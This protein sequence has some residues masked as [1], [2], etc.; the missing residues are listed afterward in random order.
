MS[1]ASLENVLK[2]PKAAAGKLVTDKKGVR[3]YNSGS[4]TYTKNKWVK[5][6]EKS[7]I[8]LQ[9]DMRRPDGKHIIKKDIISI[10]RKAGNWLA[11]NWQKKVLSLGK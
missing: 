5:V 1:A 9:T 10:K 8:L 6:R 7:I 11:D 3:Y 4:K 2:A